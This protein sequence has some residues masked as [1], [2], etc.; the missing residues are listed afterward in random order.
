MPSFDTVVS[1]PSLFRAWR[2]FSVGKKN[3][4]DVAEYAL[5]IVSN[6]YTL[7]HDL[8]LGTYHHG[9]Y[10]YFRV[11]DSKPRDIHK[12]SVRDRIVHHAIYQALYPYFD[13]R[14]I[15]DSYSCRL[16]KG[17]HQALYRFE[18]LARKVGKNHTR[19]V[20][21]LKCDIRKCFASIDHAV[22]KHLLAKHIKDSRL[23]ELCSNV[24]DS[25][26]S[27]RDGVG[28][29]LGNLTSQLFINIYLNELDQFIKH[30]RCAR[31]YIRYADDFVS[32]S[33][34][35]SHLESL[36]DPIR[37]FAQLRLRLSIH[38]DKQFLRTVASGVD[39]L[40][41]VHFP[42]HRVLRTS[43]KRRMFRTLHEN[44]GRDA[45]VESYVGLLMHGNGYQLQKQITNR[46][47]TG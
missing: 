19:T 29:P 8:I 41:W 5:R 3:K 36:I 47:I 1:I 20:W 39:F 15:H 45:S 22:L 27:T 25:F 17:T 26:S 28:I 6:L 34:N 46:S 32:M 37:D 12:A 35:R 44:G 38:E 33:H 43:T 11:N 30:E 16:E 31:Y 18:Q 23:S 14:F 13:K 2:A 42:D 10:C 40:G 21:V 9:S 4:P 7:H 24:I